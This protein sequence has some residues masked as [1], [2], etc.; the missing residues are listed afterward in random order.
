MDLIPAGESVYSIS[1]AERDSIIKS[2]N[3]LLPQIFNYE[4]PE[5][6]E[7]PHSYYICLS[8]LLKKN[9]T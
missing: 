4:F 2:L 7:F 3:N 5:S 1:K 6:E 8:W 9:Q